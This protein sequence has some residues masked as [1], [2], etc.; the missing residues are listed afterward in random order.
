MKALRICVLFAALLGPGCGAPPPAATTYVTTINPL[1][2]IVAEVAGDRAEV[3]VLLAPGASP[4][5]YEPRPSD[6]L[7]AESAVALFCAADDIDGWAAK[8][9]AKERVALFDLVPKAQRLPY[10]DE[11]HADHDGHAH[12]HGADNGHFWS[13]PA[14]VKSILPQLADRMSVLDPGGAGTYRANAARFA[15]DLDTLDAEL[16][17]AFGALGGRPVFMFHPSWSYFM[18]RYGVAVAGMVEPY[19]GKES[20]PKYLKGLI[21]TAR[22]RGVRAVFTEPQ[23]PRRPAEVIAEECGLP[24]FEID[25]NGGV[26]GRRTYRE[27]IEYNA[28]MLKKALQ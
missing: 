4:H 7:A 19:P 10:D 14:I 21:D 1:R 17:A 8:L 15:D 3:T 24:L 23:L 2:A 5:T 18:H 11:G 27:L 6:A 12:E 28:A 26:E 25:P 9:P 13:D 16:K 22:A 20:S